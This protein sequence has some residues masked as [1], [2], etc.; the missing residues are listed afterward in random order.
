MGNMMNPCSASCW[1]T[2][3]MKASCSRA[4]RC[5]WLFSMRQ[6]TPCPSCMTVRICH[7]RCNDLISHQGF[8][9]GI[10]FDLIGDRPLTERER[11]QIDR[12]FQLHSVKGHNAVEN[13]V[14]V[15]GSGIILFS[16]L[17]FFFSSLS[18]RSFCFRIHLGGFGPAFRW[19]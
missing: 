2:R 5:S 8:I 4:F 11:V 13:L 12:E 6:R 16:L 17:I 18:F 7:L 14:N 1:P 3:S 19:S 9:P 15:D 10:S